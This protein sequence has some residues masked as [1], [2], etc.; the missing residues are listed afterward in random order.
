MIPKSLA[1]FATSTCATYAWMAQHPISV[2]DWLSAPAIGSQC[3]TDGGSQQRSTPRLRV[4][5]GP[6]GYSVTR[7]LRFFILTSPVYLVLKTEFTS[8]TQE[9]IPY[10]KRVVQTDI[11]ATSWCNPWNHAIEPPRHAVGTNRQLVSHTHRPQKCWTK[12]NRTHRVAP[13]SPTSQRNALGHF[14]DELSSRAAHRRMAR[15]RRFPA[16]A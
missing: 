9:T 8:N 16:E 10:A 2:P 7:H 13:S 12:S 5:K 1:L 3:G 15:E 6:K 4:D 11:S 14:G